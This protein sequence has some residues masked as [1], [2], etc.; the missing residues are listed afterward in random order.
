[1]TP[2]MEREVAELRAKV[3][4]LTNE[5]EHARQAHAE[6]PADIAQGEDFYALTIYLFYY[7][8]EQLS[9]GYKR[10][11]ARSQ[12]YTLSVTWNAIFSRLAPFMLDE[13]SERDL[14]K[15]L[16]GFAVALLAESL[17]EGEVLPPDYG[18]DDRVEVAANVIQDVKVQ[19]F[20]L[21]LISPSE[22]RRA[23]TD[24]NAY[25]TLTQTGRGQLMRLRAIRRTTRQ[26]DE[27]APAK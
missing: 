11:N 6:V 25:W 24:K 22:R 27:S 17:D 1:M 5:L 26:S 4:E 8:E 23:V 9:K 21:G 15:E 10:G 7:T 16:D 12:W 3:A 14:D 20:A 19:L 2:E 13:A 18:K